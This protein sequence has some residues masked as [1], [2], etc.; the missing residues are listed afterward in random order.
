MKIFYEW[1]TVAENIGAATLDDANQLVRTI[2]L[3]ARLVNTE[4]H[5]DNIFTNIYVTKSNGLWK[6]RSVYG[7]GEVSL[8]DIFIIFQNKIPEQKINCY[9]LNSDEFHI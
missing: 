6:P 1:K 8:G 4:F 9:K 7:C 3:C 2:R 5:S